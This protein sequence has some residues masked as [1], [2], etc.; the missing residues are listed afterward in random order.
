MKALKIVLVNDDEWEWD[1]ED[2]EIESAGIY[3]TNFYRVAEK[4]K[5]EPSGHDVFGKEKKKV[6]LFPMANIISI[7]EFY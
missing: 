5:T 6:F 2:D 7:E 4:P 1:E 3:D